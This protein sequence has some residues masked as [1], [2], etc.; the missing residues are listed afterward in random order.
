MLPPENEAPGS[1][2]SPP[3]SFGYW[4]GHF[5]VVASMVGAGILSTSGFTLRD[6]GNPAALLGLWLVGGLMALAG[7][8][9]IAELATALPQAGGD[10]VFVRDAFGRGAA[11]TAGWA[12]FV[13]GF[14]APTAVV[15]HI[16]ITFLL[17]PHLRWIA[18]ALPHLVAANLIPIGATA[19]TSAITAAHCLG[20]RESGRLQ[21]V[22]TII[23]ISLLFG[24]AAAGLAIGRGSWTHLDAG[25]WPTHDQWPALAIGLIYV[26]YAYSGWDG[27]AYL[28]G[29]IREPARLLPRCLIGGTLTVVV[30]YLLVN[31]AYV[32]ALD[33]AAVTAME[34]NE[35]EKIAELAAAHLFGQSAAN[36]IATLLGLSLVASVSAYV[37]T[38]PRVIFA[39]ARDGL[40]PAFAG[41]L[42]SRRHIPI[43]ATIT[44]GVLAIAFIWSG[45]FQDLLNYTSVG[46]AAVSGLV[47]ASIFPIRRR[48]DLPHPYRMPLYPFLPIGYLALVIWTIAYHLLQ[49]DK[50]LP[51]VLSLVTLFLGIPLARLVRYFSSR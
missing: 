3:R 13:I 50:R 33:P 48:R 27:A 17:A 6:T 18:A 37:L 22:I 9:T 16:S 36:V 47:I 15:S 2:Q 40:F 28:A 19:L 44:Q 51:A 31:L 12:T 42:H 29:E 32:Y 5:V 14:A 24:L 34:P 20:Q 43:W 8:L 11:F 25:A 41:R 49:A 23:K 45:T 10:Y 35:V 4:A 7:A 1:T 38:G 39:M 30:L 21:V 26:S 46:L